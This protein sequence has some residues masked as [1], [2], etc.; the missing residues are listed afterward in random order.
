MIRSYIIEHQLWTAFRW[1]S[2]NLGI[3]LWTAPLHMQRMYCQEGMSDS[4]HSS[5]HSRY[6]MQ[7][8]L[9]YEY[10]VGFRSNRHPSVTVTRLTKFLVR[11]LEDRDKRKISSSVA[12]FWAILS[13]FLAKLVVAISHQGENYIYIN[14]IWAQKPK[15]LYMVKCHVQTFRQ[16]LSV[17]RDKGQ[18]SA[19]QVPSVTRDRRIDWNHTVS[20]S[21]HPTCLPRSGSFRSSRCSSSVFLA[22]QL[23]RR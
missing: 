6:L 7:G 23:A 1:I 8:I 4:F 13:I 11:H 20:V 22:H 17:T 10:T 18:I 3:A 15:I 19:R 9:G 21:D 2:S 5:P 16:D 12:D 14:I